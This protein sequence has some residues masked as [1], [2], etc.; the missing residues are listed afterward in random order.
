MG[1]ATGILCSIFFGK[2]LSLNI[3]L[4]SYGWLGVIHP[5]K[6]NAVTKHY[7]ILVFYAGFFTWEARL[8]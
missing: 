6:S 1:I 4:F 2:L 5:Q 8:G 7:F 3:A